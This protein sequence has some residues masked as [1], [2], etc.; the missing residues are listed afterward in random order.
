MTIFD[1]N[2]NELPT[3][4]VGEIVIRSDTVTPGYW[5]NGAP[6]GSDQR[7]RLVPHR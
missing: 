6:R 2:D 4:E 1:D 5:N 7:R 3:G